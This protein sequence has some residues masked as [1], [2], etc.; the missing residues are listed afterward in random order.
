MAM[1][2]ANR[3]SMQPEPITLVVI[4]PSMEAYLLLTLLAI[5][6][7][8]CFLAGCM[9]HSYCCGTKKIAP[10]PKLTTANQTTI[11]D[12]IKLYQ[13]EHDRDHYLL[14]QAFFLMFSYR[15]LCFPND[16]CLF[17]YRL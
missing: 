10:E 9:C 3:V 6:V 14:I 2:L 4:Y 1:E 5:I 15:K 13:I 7:C 16:F 8:S 12:N 17:S 11:P